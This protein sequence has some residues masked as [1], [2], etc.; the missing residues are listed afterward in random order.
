M[1]GDR[2]KSCEGGFTEDLACAVAMVFESSPGSIS[3]SGVEMCLW[4][5]VAGHRGL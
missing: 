5:W 2:G 1:L 4:V 3:T